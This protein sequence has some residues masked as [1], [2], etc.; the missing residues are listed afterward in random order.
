VR[1]FERGFRSGDAALCDT[2]D[3]TRL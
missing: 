2:F 1:W 3:T